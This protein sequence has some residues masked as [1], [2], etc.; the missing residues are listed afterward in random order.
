MPTGPMTAT[1]LMELRER[2]GLMITLVAVTIGLPT[3][4]L[5]IRLLLHAIAPKTY[6]PAGGYVNFTAMSAG[7]LYIFGF[8]V[9][10]SLGCTAGSVDLSEECSGTW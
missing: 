5:A 9:A 7:V 10:A 3:V 6:G 2:R 1:R 4:Y 8:I